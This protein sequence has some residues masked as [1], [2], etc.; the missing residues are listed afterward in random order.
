MR[1][2]KIN[3]Q[4]YNH[5]LKKLKQQKT[6]TCNNKSI[7]IIKVTPNV[8][9]DEVKIFNAT[10]KIII[11][12]PKNTIPVKSIET[13][14][15]HLGYNNIVVVLFHQLFSINELMDIKNKYKNY[16]FVVY[17]LEQLSC[18]DP[19]NTT[20]IFKKL[21]FFDEIWEYDEKNMNILIEHNYNNVK[22]IKLS[23][24]ESLKTINPNINK[25]IDVLFYG[26]INNK[27][28]LII[29]NLKNNGINV[30]VLTNTYDDELDSYI[31]RSKI[32]LNTHYYDANIQE[33]VRL[34][35]L[36]I[37]NKCVVSEPSVINNYGD[38]IIETTN[39]LEVIND[40]LKNDKWEYYNNISESF[41]KI[42]SEIIPS[43]ILESK[44]EFILPTYNRH[45][46][47][48]SV[49]YALKA[50]TCNRWIAHVVIDGDDNINLYK[51]IINSFKGDLQIKFTILSKRYNDWGH[52]PRNYG[53]ENSTEKWVIMSG[54]DN[55]YIPIFVEKFLSIIDDNTNFVYCD[56]I[57]NHYNYN[58]YFTC[59]PKLNK[60]DIGN[61]MI[62]SDY[63]K[64]LEL[65][66]TE[67]GADGIYCEEYIKKYCKELNNIKYI[68][69]ALYVHN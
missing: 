2:K 56:M 65:I 69:Q 37:N 9:N 61:F 16:K 21:D 38:L 6:N 28:Q 34:F 8:K 57:H 26:W 33:Q 48:L 67:F 31:A 46:S 39:Y 47:L 30:V 41:K 50:Q 4:T 12:K 10:N 44:I 53:L 3:K 60:I 22:L 5:Q 7:N 32:I 64:T 29:D 36:V 1:N 42:T 14:I 62:R 54:D 25:D 58:S 24:C 68:K 66:T 19:N 49:L 52:T 27:R 55:Y 17:Q 35:H 63:G 15:K 13:F 20:D 23:Y 43:E 18:Y 51:P 59:E 40:L 45:N 11:I